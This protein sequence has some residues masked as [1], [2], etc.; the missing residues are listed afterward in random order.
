VIAAKRALRAAVETGLA[1]G[2]DLERTLFNQLATTE[3]RQEGRQAFRE[4]RPP[5][6]KGR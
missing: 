3:D 2:L 1:A 5:N 6:F 4:R